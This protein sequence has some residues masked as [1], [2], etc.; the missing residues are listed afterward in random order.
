M[1]DANDSLVS[2]IELE[3]GGMGTVHATRRATGHQNSIGVRVYGDE[4]AVE[5]DLDR[6]PSSYRLV[7]GKKATRLAQWRVVKSARTLTQHER[8]ITCIRTG[9]DDALDLRNGAKVQARLEASVQ[10]SRLAAP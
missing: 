2:T 1:L 8:F 6:D 9:K 7:K 4:G 10:S 5:V 3:A